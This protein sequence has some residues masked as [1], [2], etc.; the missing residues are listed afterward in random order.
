MAAPRFLFIPLVTASLFWTNAPAL[1]ASEAPLRLVVMPFQNLS[2]QPEDEWLA[3]SFS[4]NLTVALAQAPSLQVIERSQIHLV[5]QEQAFA[6]SA[7]AD[8]ESAPALGKLMGA[9]KML[10]GNYQKV[11]D[12]LLINA[13]VIDVSTGLVEAQSALQLEGKL[14]DLFQ[15]QRRLSSQ[16]LQRLATPTA[17]PSTTTATNVAAYQLYQQAQNQL[18]GYAPRG[19]E[20]GIQLLEAALQQDPHYLPAQASLAEALAIGYAQAPRSERRETLPARIREAAQRVLNTPHLQ[21]QGRRALALLSQAQGRSAEAQTHLQTALAQAPGDVSTLLCYLKVR[22]SRGWPSPQVL[23]QELR[24]LQAPLTDPQVRLR[25]AGAYIDQFAR[26]S[27]PHTAPV[28]TLLT[29]LEQELPNDVCIQLKLAWLDVFDRQYFQ[30]RERL[31]KA[32]QRNPDNYLLPYLAASTLLYPALTAPEHAPWVEAQLRNSL[33]QYPEFGY[34]HMTLGYLL[35]RQGRQ[36]E[37]VQHFQQATTLLPE[38]AALHFSR[39]KYAY[40]LRRLPEAR[41]ELELALSRWGQ[42]GQEQIARGPMLGLMAKVLMALGDAPQA[43]RYAQAAL[44]EEMIYRP[45]AVAVQAQLYA[46]QKRFAEA[47]ETLERFLQVAPEQ[48]Q[49]EDIQRAWRRVSLLERLAA[50]PQDAK[51]LNDLGQIA[52]IELD[53]QAATQYLTQAQKLAPTEATIHFNLGY[54]ALQQQAWEEAEQA[55]EVSLTLDDKMAATWFNL[56][57]AQAQQGRSGEARRAF[58]QALARDPSHQAAQA[59]LAAQRS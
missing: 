16:V 41:S 56:G 43:E 15:I 8:T 42:Q 29:E 39:A 2:R 13:R 21:A 38:S 55:F 14:A 3:D 46:M 22:H 40:S 4:E 24:S 19:I 44:S 51:A 6:Q 31:D 23:E 37:G 53:Y 11:G 7:L 5:L 32:M 57:L 26:E 35:L 17:N 1:A 27:A 36:N 48:A 49:N 20:A 12:Q 10:L 45:T 52:L 47:K 59:M 30:A 58:E 54:L 18:R 50:N 34:A 33:S 9:R 25:L 28:R